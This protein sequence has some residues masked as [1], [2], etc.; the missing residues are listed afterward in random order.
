MEN[1]SVLVVEDEMEIAKVV[2]AYLEKEGFSVLVAHN[3]KDALELFN[4]ENVNFIVLDLMLPDL[5]GEEI[6]KKIRS[7]SAVPILMLTAKAEEYDRIHGLDIGA[8]DYLTK[9][10]SPKEL[11]ARIKAIL[12]RTDSSL[13]K[14][15]IL[16]FGNGHL[17]I[18]LSLMETKKAGVSVDLTNTEYK[19]LSLLVQNQGKVFTRD[20]LITKI[21]GYDYEGFD[22]TIDVHIKNIRHKIEDSSHKY[23]VTVYGVG[24]KFIGEPVG[25]YSAKQA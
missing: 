9:P 23:I 18:D 3:G 11:I 5:S 17:T 20:S 15:N 16:E 19:L 12:R 7:V 1:I 6:C 21:L 22:R 2:S 14:A 4:R 24:Y 10:F 8:D 13:A 25:D